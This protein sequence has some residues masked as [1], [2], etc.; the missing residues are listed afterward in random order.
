MV[1]YLEHCITNLQDVGLYTART[2]VCGFCFPR[3][4]LPSVTSK[5]FF[6]EH[7]Q[8]QMCVCLFVCL[9]V[10]LCVCQNN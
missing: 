5:A 6:N 3:P 4:Y 1:Q 9:C 8:I 7:T 10:C 2:C